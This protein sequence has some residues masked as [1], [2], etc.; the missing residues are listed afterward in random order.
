MNLGKMGLD[1][2]WRLQVDDRLRSSPQDANAWK[3]KGEVPL[4]VVFSKP[5]F[6]RKILFK[7]WLFPR[8]FNSKMA[9]LRA[10]LQRLCASLVHWLTFR[11]YNLGLI[12][13]HR[14]TFLLSL[15][16]LKTERRRWGP[17]SQMKTIYLDYLA[18]TC[19]D[20]GTTSL[21]DNSWRRLSTLTYLILSETRRDVNGGTDLCRRPHVLQVLR[22]DL[23]VLSHW[24]SRE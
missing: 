23:R 22:G 14:V 19:R 9:K 20:F 8:Y 13:W 12:F 4:L 24:R 17:G 10:F 7:S 5:A 11:N 15:L 18:R 21:L 16:G 1:L 3:E 2:G 6:K